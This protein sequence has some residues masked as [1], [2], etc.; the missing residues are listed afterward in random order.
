LELKR[1]QAESKINI[2]AIAFDSEGNIMDKKI[3]N[4]DKLPII[5]NRGDMRY[6]GINEPLMRSSYAELKT[7]LKDVMGNKDDSPAGKYINKKRNGF[8]NDL[9]QLNAVDK[10][11]LDSVEAGG[12]F[13]NSFVPSNGVT[14]AEG[15]SNVKKGE[16]YQADNNI[17]RL[18]YT[19]IYSKKPIELKGILTQSQSVGNLHIKKNKELSFYEES[20][21][22]PINFPGNSYK[23]ERDQ[24]MTKEF[25]LDQSAI[26]TVKRYEHNIIKGT[27]ITE[28]VNF[29]KS[30]LDDT[31]LTNA[32]K[33][34]RNAQISV[35]PKY[36]NR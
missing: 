28:L 23:Q 34:S 27:D 8:I 32:Y 14:I 3:V 35:L 26:P 29:D 19:K 13:F 24:E 15:E 11:A 2:N 5:G 6:S 21:L 30:L 4:C 31:V 17:S 33:T 12:S 10:H 20:S 25:E 7:K 9:P 16:H 18:E 22:P 36:V 1:R